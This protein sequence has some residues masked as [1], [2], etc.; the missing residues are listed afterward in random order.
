MIKTNIGRA[1]GA[2]VEE[3]TDLCNELIAQREEQGF[4][5][6]EVTLVTTESEGYWFIIYFRKEEED[7]IE[8]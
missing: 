6:E 5:V 7:A 3:A 1:F 2:S 4:E 8:K